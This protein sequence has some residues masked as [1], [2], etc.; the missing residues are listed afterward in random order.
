LS[1]RSVDKRFISA[2]KDMLHEQLQVSTTIDYRSDIVIP[3]VQETDNI[4]TVVGVANAESNPIRTQP[5]SYW[6]CGTISSIGV[7]GR[8]Y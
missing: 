8:N 2:E 4:Q 5:K 7:L 3:G 6:S 1:D